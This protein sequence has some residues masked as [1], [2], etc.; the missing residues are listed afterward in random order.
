[1]HLI[2]CIRNIQLCPTC[3]ERVLRSEIENHN[4]EFHSV[5]TCGECNIKFQSSESENH[6][7]LIIYQLE[8]LGKLVC[9][10]VVLVHF[11]ERF[12]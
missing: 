12:L 8:K 2:Y 9:L 11:S 5:I 4:E 1:M 7:V 3:D 6:K 10:Y